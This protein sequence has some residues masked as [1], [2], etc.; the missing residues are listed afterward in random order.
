MKGTS[1]L[2]RQG[3]AILPI[4]LALLCL[5]GCQKSEIQRFKDR[6]E[7][8]AIGMTEDEADAVLAGMKAEHD[9]LKETI[10]V[11]GKLITVT[12]KYYE[13]VENSRE[14]N[15][16]LRVQFDEHGHVVGKHISSIVR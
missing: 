12:T 1:M 2:A 11:E 15:F 16:V 5:G 3:L 14:G 4:G 8:I 9:T 6:S 10:T 13:E 7:R